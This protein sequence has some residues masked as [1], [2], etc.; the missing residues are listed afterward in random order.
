M[1][2]LESATIAALVGA[3]ILL[4]VEV[5]HLENTRDG[6]RFAVLAALGGGLLAFLPVRVLGRSP[7]YAAL[8]RGKRRALRA[9]IVLT[10]ALMTTSLS[11]LAN[12]VL[13]PSTAYAATYTLAGKG[14]SPVGR[15][16]RAEWYLFIETPSRTER[17]IVDRE[18]WDTV[19]VGETIELLEQPS[20]LGYPYIAAYRRALR[21]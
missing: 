11:S 20:F 19:G 1:R 18:F 8:P 4:V 16:G 2:L 21:R 10:C 9:C 12:R 7:A 13:A 17:V 15:Q 14:R 6:L 3:L 5:P